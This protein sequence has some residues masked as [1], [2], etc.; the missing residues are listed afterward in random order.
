MC[1]GGGS[2]SP[3]NPIVGRIAFWTDDLSSKV[4]VNTASEGVYWDPPRADNLEE[5]AFAARTPGSREWQRHPGHPAMVSMSSILAPG[6]RYYA[7]GDSG[8]LPELS[9]QEA[10]QFW[11]ATP[12]VASGEGTIG[13]TVDAPLVPEADVDPPHW[14]SLADFPYSSERAIGDYEFFLTTDSS[15]PEETFAGFPRVSTWPLPAQ[16]DVSD[17]RDLAMQ[18]ASTVGPGIFAFRRSTNDLHSD[19]YELDGGHNQVLLEQYLIGAFPNPAP[20]LSK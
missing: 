16:N 9:L 14:Q 6:R 7:P 13:G 18:E 20:G 2:I 5:R 12:G 8:D 10:A 11:A 1:L 19:F 17:N 4:N 15:A 3:D